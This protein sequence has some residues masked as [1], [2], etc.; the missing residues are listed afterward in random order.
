MTTTRPANTGC[1]VHSNDG[2]TTVGRR[3]IAPPPPP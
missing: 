2:L 3:W 1:N